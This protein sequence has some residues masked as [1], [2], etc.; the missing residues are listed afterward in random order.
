MVQEHVS[1]VHL[2]KELGSKKKFLGIILLYINTPRQYENGKSHKTKPTE[3]KTFT[4]RIGS[5]LNGENTT[6]FFPLLVSCGC[7]VDEK[8]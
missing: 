7:S 1:Q 5:I 3:P 6:C 8:S 2:G 4:D